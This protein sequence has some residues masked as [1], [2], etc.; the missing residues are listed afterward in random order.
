MNLGTVTFTFYACDNCC[1]VGRHIM[2]P[3]S[4]LKVRDGSKGTANLLDLKSGG[5]CKR[6]KSQV[7]IITR[8][9]YMDSVGRIYDPDTCIYFPNAGQLVNYYD[10]HKPFKSSCPGA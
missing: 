6:C 9:C 7:R 2:T 3:D 4:E 5:A 10:D 8:I 1:L